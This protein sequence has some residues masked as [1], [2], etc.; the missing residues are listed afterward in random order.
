MRRHI[1][2]QN[3]NYF[4]VGRARS[5]QKPLWN[6]IPFCAITPMVRVFPANFTACVIFMTQSYVLFQVSFSMM[7]SDENG[8]AVRWCL[9]I[10]FLEYC[11]LDKD[12]CVMDVEQD[13]IVLSLPKSEASRGLWHRIYAGTSEASLK[14]CFAFEFHNV[15]G[16]QIKVMQ[17]HIFGLI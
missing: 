15:D 4:I 12:M 2:R 17:L 11:R 14:V 6:F 7:S 13:K 1:N 3:E 9:L 8:E 5:K 10:K 16:V